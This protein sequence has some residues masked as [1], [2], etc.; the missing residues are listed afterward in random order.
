MEHIKTWTFL[1]I[2]VFITALIIFIKGC[3]YNFTAG[4]V[5]AATILAMYYVVVVVRNAYV[6]RNRY[7]IKRQVEEPRIIVA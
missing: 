6:S 5:Y 1:R 7:Y 4:I 3:Y 2:L